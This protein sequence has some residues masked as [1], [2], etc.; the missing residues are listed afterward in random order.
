VKD[1]VVIKVIV[2]TQVN[3]CVCLVSKD[4]TVMNGM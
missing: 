1:S 4:R 2:L 3:V